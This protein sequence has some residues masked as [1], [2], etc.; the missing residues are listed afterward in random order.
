MFNAKLTP[1]EKISK[2]KAYL[3]K[4]K[5]FFAYIVDR[6]V[7]TET[8][9]I[10]TMAVDGTGKMLYNPEFV[11]KLPQKELAGVVMHEGLHAALI[12]VWR[13]KGK[14]GM[15]WNIATD[16]VVN[17]IVLA[18]GESLPK[19]G[20]I[21]N[22]DEITIGGITITEL[23]KKSAEDV[24]NILK[25]EAPK[26]KDGEGQDGEGEGQE[27]SDGRSLSDAEPKNHSE[28]GKGSGKEEKDGKSE[29]GKAG[30]PLTPEQ[31]EKL[32]K[33]WKKIL[34]SASTYAKMQ[35]QSPLGCDRELEDLH[36]SKVNWRSIL[37]RVVAESLP[38]DYSWR[39]PNRKYIWNDTYLP[40]TEGESVRVLVSL[41]TSGSVGGEELTAYVSEMLGIARSF[42]SVDFR[43]LCHDTDVYDMGLI[44]NGNRQNL[45]KIKPKGGGGTDH[46]QLL[47]YIEKKRYHKKE[48][49]LLISFT[50]GFSSFPN[51]KPPF[52]TVVV[53]VGQHRADKATMPRWADVIEVV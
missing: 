13:L 32:Q 34:E 6:L 21:P 53:L 15:L 18:N 16:I 38:S 5:P 26:Q 49:K 45:K 17:R 19:E 47:E 44:R 50:D 51:K 8:T 23:S 27:G 39:K 37:R 20:I 35:G 33:K 52:R 7:V 46:C 36:Q 43:V 29:K 22:G 10:P 9:I 14:Q 40:S 30:K 3:F 1:R 31:M 28:W 42:A 48:T 24:Y 41:D 12:H 11:E 4:R 25:R 2:A